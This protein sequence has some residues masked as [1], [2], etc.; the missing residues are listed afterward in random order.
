MVHNLEIINYY[1]STSH[2][3]RQTAR[4]FNLPIVY[5]AKIILKYK[6]KYEI[7]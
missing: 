3:I 5:V 2:G 6:K 7:R 4:R 1:F